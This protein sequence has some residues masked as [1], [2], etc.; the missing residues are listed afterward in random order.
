MLGLHFEGQT[1][2]IPLFLHVLFNVGKVEQPF[3]EF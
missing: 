3:L 1:L 2:Q